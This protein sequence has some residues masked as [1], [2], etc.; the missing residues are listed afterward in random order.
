ME[1]LG[2]LAVVQEFLDRAIRSP[3]LPPKGLRTDLQLRK[4]VLQEAQENCRLIESTML[5][6]QSSLAVAISRFTSSPSSGS[7]PSG[8][9][10]K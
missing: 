3:L 9:S 7:S 1:T 2:I 6:L 8:K 10:G 4:I 5:T